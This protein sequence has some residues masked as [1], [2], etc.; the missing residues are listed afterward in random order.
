[1]L[2]QEGDGL[3]RPMRGAR[4]PF[5]GAHE[6][7]GPRHRAGERPVGFGLPASAQCRWS[8]VDGSGVRRGVVAN[9]RVHRRRGSFQ[10]AFIRLE[11]RCQDVGYWT[12]R[13][14]GRSSCK[15]SLGYED[16]VPVGALVENQGNWLDSSEY[17]R[18]EEYSTISRL[19]LMM[20]PM[21]AGMSNRNI[22]KTRL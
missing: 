2:Q 9:R 4:Q 21:L 3:R 1:M 13:L 7:H 10:R 18:S 22:E 19:W 5:P 8:F 12:C 16:F 17:I 11:D 14:R 6:P 15:F 20:Y